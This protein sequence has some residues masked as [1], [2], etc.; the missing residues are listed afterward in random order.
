MFLI[1]PWEPTPGVFTIMGCTDR[2]PFLILGF[3][4]GKV[5]LWYAATVARARSTAAPGAARSRLYILVWILSAQ[6]R[7]GKGLIKAYSYTHSTL[8]RLFVA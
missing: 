4:G 7:V 5:T 2:A 3:L 1:D 6:T 8:N